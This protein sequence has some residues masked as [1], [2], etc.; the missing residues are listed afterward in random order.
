M[1]KK[2]AG[3]TP[4]FNPKKSFISDENIISAMPLVK[5]IING[6]GINLI[7]APSLANHIIISIT[8]A[9]KV[10]M[11]KPLI[12]YCCTIPYTITMKAPVGPP[13]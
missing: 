9:M 12:P 10:A 4:I 6:C 3:T 5:P 2:S 13:I 7:I 11:I 1:S 8:P